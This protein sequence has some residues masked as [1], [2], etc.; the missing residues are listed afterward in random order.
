MEK[1]GCSTSTN[2]LFRPWRRFLAVLAATAWMLSLWPASAPAA[3]QF[4]A[5]KPVESAVLPTHIHVLCQTPV[6]GRFPFFAITNVE[7][8]QANRMLALM[9]G[10]ELGDKFLRILFDP[11]DTSGASF[12]CRVE[13]CRIIKALILIERTPA[14]CE[15]DNTQLGCAGF[16]AAHANDDPSC[17][18][19]CASHDDERC[20]GNCTRHPANAACT[21]DPDPCT[22]PNAGHNPACKK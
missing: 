8:R 2:L 11:A 3:D 17:P 21:H 7:P 5:C 12:G 13:D 16:C 9:V 4:S 18:G 14:A 19:Y 15:F 22:G 10:A 1:P 6:D 20:A